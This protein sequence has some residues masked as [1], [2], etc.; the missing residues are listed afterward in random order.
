MLISVLLRLYWYL[1]WLPCNHALCHTIWPH[2]LACVLLRVTSIFLL[3]SSKSSNMLINKE[4]SLEAIIRKEYNLQYMLHI[5]TETLVFTDVNLLALQKEA[6]FWGLLIYFHAS[7]T[8]IWEQLFE[9]HNYRKKETLIKSLLSYEVL[10]SS[11]WSWRRVV[12]IHTFYEVF[13]PSRASPRLYVSI[14]NFFFFYFN[15]A[16]ASETLIL[17]RLKIRYQRK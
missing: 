8:N 11:S 10:I 16:L 9:R 3:V 14:F 4:T 17:E 13:S 7:I 15:P 5:Q 6:G 12:P 1:Q 2:L